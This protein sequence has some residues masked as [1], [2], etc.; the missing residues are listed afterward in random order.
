[1]NR[2]RR[3]DIADVRGVIDRHHRDLS[4]GIEDNLQSLA[5]EEQEAYDNYSP[6]L[7]M[8]D[9]GERTRE[10]AQALQEA[11][12]EFNEGFEALQRCLDKLDEA[13]DL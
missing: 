4:A 5:D 11:Q 6:G 13:V 12:H 9:Q 10:A 1:M 8:S 3:K 7:Q 2:A